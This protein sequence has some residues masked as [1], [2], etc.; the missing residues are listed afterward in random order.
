MKNENKC[1]VSYEIQTNINT[2]EAVIGYFSVQ[3]YKIV[4]H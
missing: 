4:Y 3:Y 2:T 1:M